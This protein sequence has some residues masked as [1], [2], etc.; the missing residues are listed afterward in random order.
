VTHTLE[1]IATILFGVAIIHTFSVSYF[2]HL[3]VKFPEGSMRENLF[4]LLGEVEIVFGLWAGVLVIFIAIIL[5]SD[6]AIHYVEGRNFTEPAFV[7]AIMTIASTKPIIQ[8]AQTVLNFVSKLLP[9]QR[10]IAFYLTVLILGPLLG[11]FITEP[12]AITVT[13]LILKRFF[14][15]R[16][17]SN[18]FRYGTLGILFVN[19]SV[20][21]ALTHYAAPPV[22]MVAKTWNWDTM[23]MLSTFGWKAALACC[24]NA[25]LGAYIFRKDLKSMSSAIL[26]KAEGAKKVP[27]L[28]MALYLMFLILVV[29][30]AHHIPVFMGFLLFFLG[31]AAVTQE[32]NDHLKI[33]ESLLVAFFLAGLIT[34]GGLQQWWLEPLLKDMQP[35]VLFIGAT[36]LT[37]VTDNAALTYL[38]SLIPNT[39]DTFRY[40]LMAGA[41]AG[42]GLTVIA[43]A[44]NPAGFSILRDSFED[45]VIN[46][47]GLLIGALIPTI[48]A[49]LCFWFLPSI[50]L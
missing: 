43:N 40:A 8:I 19:I 14:I 50:V 18:R 47:L 38:G 6:Q 36:G 49:M 20:G 9:L 1:I 25:S 32:Y 42:G 16:S 3:A 26:V 15:D 2:A 31:L 4:H 28:V 35:L 33:K 11:S 37:A 13:A 27:F 5:G 7:F 44:P 12:A 22:L 21:G 34:L 46:P 39:S 29:L 45:K 10:N 17:I 23:F 48:I 41:L 30:S 24:I